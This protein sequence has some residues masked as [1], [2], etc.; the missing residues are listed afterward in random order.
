MEM[1]GACRG[2]TAI[3]DGALPLFVLVTVKLLQTSMD[4][5]VNNVTLVLKGRN[6]HIHSLNMH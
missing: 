2:S 4:D 1:P 6:V 3:S 5:A